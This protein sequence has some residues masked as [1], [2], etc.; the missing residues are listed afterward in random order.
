MSCSVVELRQYTL[1]PGQR[2]VLIDLFDRELVESQEALGMRVIG[3]FRVLD[4]ADTFFWLRGFENMQARHE[5]LRG[6]YGGP[7]WK[8]HRDRANA[9]MV[10]S[11]NVLLLRPASPGSGFDLNGLTR[12]EPDAGEASAKRYVAHILYFREPIEREFA[13]HFE[14]VVLPGLVRNGVTVPAY[15]V[16]E[17]SMNTFPALPVRE[18]ENAFVWFSV[19]GDDAVH[20]AYDVAGSYGNVLSRPV[21]IKTLAPTPR[22]LL[23]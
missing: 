15:F 4:E 5:G 21:E 8:A 12:A 16:S 22:S 9:T 1:K 13:A 2:D 23:H 10:D 3:Q 14:Q 18:D 7:T 6:F 17:R 20:Q 19:T 11:D